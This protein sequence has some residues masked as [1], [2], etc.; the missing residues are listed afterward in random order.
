[1]K[2]AP[3]PETQGD[4]YFTDY[5][6]ENEN[7]NQQWN[8]YGYDEGEN[9]DAYQYQGRAD[10]NV[11]YEEEEEV[12]QAEAVVI[13]ELVEDYNPY[14]A[15]DIG[16]CDTYSHLWSYDLF[17]SCS[18]GDEFC[19]CTY[20]EELMK[21]G[22]LSCS[23]IDL[24]PHECGVCSNCLH[25][26]CDEYLPTALIAHGLQSNTGYALAAV[27][28][29]VVLAAW[30]NSKRKR[31][32]GGILGESLMDADGIP[33]AKRDWKIK[34]GKDGL[35]T[36]QKSKK[37]VSVWLAPDVSTIPKRQPLFPDLL[38]TGEKEK[39]SKKQKLVEMSDVAEPKKRSSSKR[40][41][42]TPVIV[43]SSDVSIPSSLSS[44]GEADEEDG[45]LTP[46]DGI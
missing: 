26:I 23:D 24:C 13:E 33:Y 5:G 12:E 27:I 32:K 11:Q 38:E 17:S 34:V 15:F 43:T 36:D 18:A 31:P 41:H 2:W 25:S 19:E 3:V 45:F 10:D 28:T 4:D 30:V 35:P 14:A 16:K 20:A 22:L 9:N 37:K 44:C 42:L 29:T 1:M 46:P 39:G 7:W 21:M 8:N 6:Y 40:R